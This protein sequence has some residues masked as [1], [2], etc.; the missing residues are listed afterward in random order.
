MLA[1]MR[2]VCRDGGRVVVAD[3]MASPDPEKAAA[4]H[5]M[6]MLRD[7]SHAR[8]LTLDEL[9][10]LYHGAGFAAPS[11]T[12]W[13]MDIDVEG[14]CSRARSPCPGANRSSAHVRGIGGGDFHGPADAAR[15]RTAL[16]HVLER[17]AERGAL[18]ASTSASRLALGWP[19]YSTSMGAGPIDITTALRDSGKV[20]SPMTRTAR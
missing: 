16:V 17:G 18:T 3:L 1:E 12:F 6:E 8:A 4:F 7:P 9:R 11:E 20:T 10:V 2:R 13:R 5:R 14:V 15:E 19:A